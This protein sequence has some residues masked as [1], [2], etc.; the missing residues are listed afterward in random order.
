MSSITIHHLWFKVTKP[1]N[2]RW[3]T[4]RNKDYIGLSGHL[5]TIRGKQ[6]Q[7]DFDQ[8]DFYGL[9]TI[10]DKVVYC[11]EIHKTAQAHECKRLSQKTVGLTI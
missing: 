8:K 2:L 4:I 10:M 9:W 7:R 11:Q 1:D 5:K 3:I 6:S